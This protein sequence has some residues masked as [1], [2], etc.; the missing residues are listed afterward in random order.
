VVGR[1][2]NLALRRSNQSVSQPEFEPRRF[3]STVP[4]YAR[5]RL[6]YPPELIA[7][8]ITMA[9][10][11]PGDGVMDLGCGPGLL[12]V[13]FAEAG[14]RVT[15]IDPEPDMLEAA[16][17]TAREAGVRVDFRHGSS[18]DLPTDLGPIH[19]VAMGRSFHWMDRTET[20]RALD[21][22]LPPSGAIAL[23]E[24][25]H[26]HTAENTWLVKMVEVGKNYGMQQ[27]AHRV[28]AAKGEYRTHVSYLFDSAFTHIE[29]VGVYVRRPITADDIVGRAFSLSMLSREKLGDRADDFERDLRAA[30]MAL[31]PEGRFTEIAELAAIVA[32]RP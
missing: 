27:A 9:G 24:D 8:V 7:R 11:A 20:L 18:F 5:F 3:R 2:A 28:L 19:L 29:R 10:L 16:R 4:Y 15:G 6:H 12:A 32:K 17:E 30:L 21:A 25:D 26:P 23:F 1:K 22:L 31:S 14:L 13:P